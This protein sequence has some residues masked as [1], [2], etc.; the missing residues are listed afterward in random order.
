M[1]NKVG[2]KGNPFLLKFLK[3]E[4]EIFSIPYDDTAYPENAIKIMSDIIINELLKKY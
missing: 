1:Y 3:N 4:N 2:E